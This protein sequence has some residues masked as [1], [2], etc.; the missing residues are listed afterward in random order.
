[1]T[2]RSAWRRARGPGL[3]VLALFAMTWTVYGGTLGHGFVWDDR[4]NVVDNAR[5]REWSAENLAGFWREPYFG[6]WIP[7]TYNAWSAVAQVAAVPPSAAHP[8]GLDPAWFHGLNVLL[9]GVAASIVFALL[10]SL[11]G[12]VAAAF[13]GAA[14]FALHPLQVEPV[15]WVTGTK[16]VLSSTLALAALALHLTPHDVATGRRRRWM[17]EVAATAAFA[18]AL[19]AKPAVAPL[20]LV[21]L[22]LRVGVQRR[23]WR[24]GAPWLLVWL[25]LAA[26]ASLLT[27]AGHHDVTTAHPPPI[28]Q[29]PLI[30][31]DALTFYLSRLFWPMHLGAVY[32]RTPEAV[33]GGHAIWWT[34]LPP[35][36]LAALAWR[37]SARHWLA[38]ALAVSA[39][40]LLPVLGFVPFRFQFY[41]TVADRYFYV[42][43]L[44]PALAVALGLPRGAGGAIAKPAAGAA[45]VVLVVLAVL[46]HRQAAVWKDNLSLW[47]HAVLVQ[48]ESPLAQ[49]N[50]GHFLLR[51][52]RGA[53]AERHL[54]RALELSPRY[55]NAM[56]SLG[57]LLLDRGDARAAIPY[58][59]SALAITPEDA[60]IAYNLGN[61]LSRVGD[62]DAAAE[63]YVAAMETPRYRDDYRAHFGLGVARLEQGRFVEAANHLT[64]VVQVDPGF[65]EAQVRLGDALRALGREGEALEAY[66]A[67][68][69]LDPGSAAVRARIDAPPPA[70]H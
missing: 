29:R 52:G 33:L 53:E 70:T 54:R 31:A 43:M 21:A 45:A 2:R 9:H 19:A 8:T 58:Y 57:N 55:A 30:A 65:L 37:T 5:V 1:M 63:Q 17:R 61:A 14:L 66:R 32:G 13:L 18:L 56:N 26:G 68:L 16:D 42:A 48:P 47:S 22:A 40:A 41:S 3:A 12:N 62:Y 39:L 67:A 15:A 4:D 34:W 10:W 69:R 35:L 44:G 6:L 23:P 24:E 50:L 20:P 49:H 38:P 60:R 64:Q 25:A 36:A 28:W 27:N 51:A 46:S 11:A 59:R 7:A